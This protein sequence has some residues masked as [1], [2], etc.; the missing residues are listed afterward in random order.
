MTEFVKPGT[1]TEVL[2]QSVE[3]A[4][5]E[6][7]AGKLFE[8]KDKRKGATC[9]NVRACA[10]GIIVL[11][12]F[13]GPAVKDFFRSRPLLTQDFDESELI[14]TDLVASEALL[15]L[16]RAL[17]GV[18]VKNITKSNVAKAV[19]RVEFKNDVGIG[20]SSRRFSIHHSKI[21]RAFEEA[22]K[23]SE[24]YDFVNKLK[25]KE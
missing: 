21:V 9:T 23:L 7:T 20:F 18:K 5:T 10:V 11:V 24:T 4:R 8:K 3:I 22:V 19:S 12:S 2:E 13:D 16:D 6:W 25:V 1:P 14:S 17:N 15:Y